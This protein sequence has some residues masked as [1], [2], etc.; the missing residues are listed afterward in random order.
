MN[1]HVPLEPVKEHSVPTYKGDWPS[2][3]RFRKRLTSFVDKNV[4]FRAECPIQFTESFIEEGYVG[5]AQ[6]YYPL[7][8]PEYLD[9]EK[10]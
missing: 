9:A 7:D 4:L 1:G 6:E 10:R 2:L 3:K 5:F 8:G